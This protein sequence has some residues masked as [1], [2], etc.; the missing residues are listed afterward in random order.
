MATNREKYIDNASDEELANRY[1]NLFEDKCE[2]C[3]Y[4]V[5]GKC[6]S[7]GFDGHN[8]DACKIGFAEWLSQEVKDEEEQT[9]IYNVSETYEKPEI[10]QITKKAWD[11]TLNR[12]DKLEKSYIP[13][14]E[15]QLKI[16]DEINAEPKQEKTADEMF[17]ELGYKRIETN[18]NWY[19]A[20]QY[21]EERGGMTAC[22]R[23][24]IDTS[25]NLYRYAK[26]DREERSCAITEAEDKAIHKKIEELKNGTN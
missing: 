8:G 1:G 16:L 19:I 23:I 3:S 10:I 6:S 15:E 5:N 20:Y 18:H 21:E 7:N 2:R 4:Q 24:I 12:L 9:K 17:E 26:Q 13:T 22:E 14:E 25:H 11:D